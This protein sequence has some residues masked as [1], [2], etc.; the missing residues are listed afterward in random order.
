MANTRL[1]LDVEVRPG[2]ES[3]AKYTMPGL[4]AFLEG[5]PRET[6][7]CFIPGDCDFGSERDMHDAETR[8]MPY[9]F[10]LRQTGKVK[11]L[12]KQVFCRNDWEPAG[13]GWEGVEYRLHLTGWTKKRRVI[14]LRRRIKTSISLA[15]LA[16]PALATEQLQFIET[17]EGAV[18]YEYMVLVT[19]LTESIA[20]VG[21]ALPRPRRRGKHFRTISRC[22][23]A[24]ELG[25]LKFLKSF[26]CN[27]MK[28]IFRFSERSRNDQAITILLVMA[29][30]SVNYEPSKFVNCWWLREQDSNL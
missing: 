28:Y 26:L 10:K 4:W 14:V 30:I 8:G 18:Q 2:N 7:P 5:L 25:T 24:R 17:D 13:Q 19:S 6:L 21:S 29:S 11:A 20:G 15:P 9:L 3:A 22:F 12:I 1:V 16:A 27:R 23:A